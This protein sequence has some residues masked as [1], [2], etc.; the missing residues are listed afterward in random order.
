[1]VFAQE[2][3]Q[4][5]QTSGAHYQT[6]CRPGSLA[7]LLSSLIRFRFDGLVVYLS[8]PGHVS[9][10]AWAIRKT[11]YPSDRAHT[12][13]PGRTRGSRWLAHNR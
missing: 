12:V 9:V 7:M 6:C 13:L 11:S 1:M 5:L 2:L 4:R 10:Q 8:M 3:F